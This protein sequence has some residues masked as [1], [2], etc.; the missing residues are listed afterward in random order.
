M[1]TCPTYVKSISDTFGPIC[2]I[3]D[4]SQT[5]SYEASKPHEPHDSRVLR[6][7]DSIDFATGQRD[8]CGSPAI[9]RSGELRAD[10]HCP[11]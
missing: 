8:V 1:D 11:T 4:I 7:D 6:L 5:L 3:F 9:P 10:F 2:G